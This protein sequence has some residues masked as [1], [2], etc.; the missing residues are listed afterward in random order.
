MQAKKP[1]TKQ[2]ILAEKGAKLLEEQA[3]VAAAAKSAKDALEAK[4]RAQQGRMISR[5]EMMIKRVTE[6]QVHETSM[7]KLGKAHA[8]KVAADQAMSSELGKSQGEGGGEF[9]GFSQFEID[10]CVNYMDPGGDNE[11]TL[12]ELMEAFRRSR[13][14]KAVEKTTLKGRKVLARIMMMI[15]TLELSL[16][17]FFKIVDGAG[18]SDGNVSMKELKIGVKHLSMMIKER[19][20]EQKR[21]DDAKKPQYR[22]LSES[23][24]VL[25]MKV[26]DPSGEGEITL[27]EFEKSVN[28]AQAPTEAQRIE[29]RVGGVFAKLEK[30]MKDKGMR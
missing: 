25:I 14:A 5:K 23:E 20:I 28:D 16:Q 4:K 13:R 1:V 17:D 11:I 8:A 22:E 12:E 29:A 27:A 10:V 2:E 18:K 3:R 21:P 6:K 9:G 24:A 30:L 26:A 7:R 19:M 15:R